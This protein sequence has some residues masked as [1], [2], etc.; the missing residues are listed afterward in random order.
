MR[1]VLPCLAFC[2]LA[3]TEKMLQ[4]ITSCGGRVGKRTFG[5]VL[6]LAQ[7]LN[8][9]LVGMFGTEDKSGAHLWLNP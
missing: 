8:H 2:V 5:Q 7:E 6:P 9:G 3:V 1:G 4:A